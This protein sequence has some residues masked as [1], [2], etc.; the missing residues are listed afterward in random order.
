MRRTAL[1]GIATIIAVLAALALWLPSSPVAA[2]TPNGSAAL[3]VSPPTSSIDVA[4]GQVLKKKISLDNI[5]DLTRTVTVETHNFS[6]NG[7][8]GEARLTEE[9]GSYSLRQWI[10]VNP[11]TATLAPHGHQDFEVTITVPNNAAPGGHFG[12]LVFS[13]AAGGA[14]SGASLSVVSQVSS[15]ILLRV[16]GDAN[17]AA[18]IHSL[19]ACTTAETEKSRCEKS[20]KFFTG[21]DL[22]FTTRVQNSGNVQV[23]PQGTV[24]VRNMFGKKVA[25]IPVTGANVLP[26]S[27]RRFE[28]KWS[29]GN[30]FGQYKITTD[31]KYGTEEQT[32]S[33]S[34][35]IWIVPVNTI[36]MVLAGLFVIFFLGWL[37][38][39]RWKK[40][41]KALAAG[42]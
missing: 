30:P 11:P 23:M 6:A 40:A 16:P 29:A 27:I 36:L 13:P 38:R 1:R 8:D 32:L 14:G 35:T 15:L 26:E 41:F 20:K 42:D 28:S 37:P 34:T 7:E 39:K 22:S 24:T 12:A 21:K 5:S 4:A 25:E 33:K 2:Q 3:S 9:E 19:N 18:S 10:K 17:E 31:L